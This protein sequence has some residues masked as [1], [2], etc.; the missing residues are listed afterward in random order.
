MIERSLP[1]AAPV[2]VSL[3]H[4]VLRTADLGRCIDFYEQLLGL[5][6]NYSM[7]NG[8]SLTY[9]GEHHR[10]ALLEVAPGTP[11]TGPGLEHIAF[12]LQNLGDL[13]GNHRR[14]SGVGIEPFVVVHHGG[15]LS[16][17]YRDPDGIQVE[18]FIDAMTPD[19]ALEHMGSEV[20]AKNPIGSP[21][22]LDDLA[23]RYEAGEPLAE[24]IAVP[25]FDE[26]DFA[27][28][29]ERVLSVEPPHT[30]AQG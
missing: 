28:M 27:A 20:F 14:L 2:A 15:T 16:A 29:L 30:S 8:A 26:R 23:R 19:L 24:L 17:Y 12:K 25:A 21:V 4:V 1:V 9:D 3:S 11:A 10:L 7:A 18:L 5:R 22:D 6:V 13:L